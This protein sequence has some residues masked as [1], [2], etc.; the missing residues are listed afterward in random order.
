MYTDLNSKLSQQVY[1][2]CCE[3]DWRRGLFDE[4]TD[5]TRYRRQVHGGE[6]QPYEKRMSCTSGRPVP[7][8]LTIE[9]GTSI[10][11][12]A[13]CTPMGKRGEPEPEG[14][15]RGPLFLYI[16][17]TGCGL[18]PAAAAEPD[19]EDSNDDVDTDDSG[20]CIDVTETNVGDL[21]SIGK[22]FLDVYRERAVCS[23]NGRILCLKA[24]RLAKPFILY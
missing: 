18:F 12:H 11:D 17:T 20:P 16:H 19:D 9:D 5:L 2:T 21:P 13:W 23:C 10:A 7:V 8:R 22:I 24:T 6:S 3:S 1:W 14:S 4:G 15:T